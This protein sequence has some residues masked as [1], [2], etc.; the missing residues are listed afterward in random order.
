MVCKFRNFLN[1]KCSFLVL[2]FFTSKFWIVFWIS[3]RSFCS[4]SDDSISAIFDVFS[5][6]VSY[7]SQ[8]SSFTDNNNWHL[9]NTKSGF[10]LVDLWFLL[11]ICRFERHRNPRHWFK[12]I[13][14]SFLASNWNVSFPEMFLLIISAENNFSNFAIWSVYFVIEL[15]FQ[16]T[17]DKS[18]WWRPMSS[19]VDANELSFFFETIVPVLKRDSFKVISFFPVWTLSSNEGASKNSLELLVINLF[20]RDS[21]DSSWILWF[22]FHS[23]T[24]YY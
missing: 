2:F 22:A 15:R 10:Q 5:T 3:F 18:A 20:K 21:I 23:K 13:W 7:K 19:K 17:V 4:P 8:R 14:I 11:F 6:V 16:N 24:N 1:Q 9:F 12:Y